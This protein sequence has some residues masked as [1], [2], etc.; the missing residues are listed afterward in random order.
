MY[1]LGIV[2]EQ[3]IY[4]VQHSSGLVFMSADSQ[5]C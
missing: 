1:V 2:H 3:L 4:I 5:R